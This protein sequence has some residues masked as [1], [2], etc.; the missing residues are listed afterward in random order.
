MDTVLI[1]G[2]GPAG[3]FCGLQA[4]GVGRR[5]VVLEK[6][7]ACGRKLL[8]TGTGQCN[9]THGG[10]VSE[11]L[12]HYGDHGTFLRPALMNFNNLDLI[13][14][15][16]DHGVRTITEP[17]GKVFPE[18]RKATEVLDALLNCCRERGVEVRCNE[19]VQEVRREQDGF[20]VRTEA[21]TYHAD[22]LVIA[23]GG[24]SY[25]ATGSTGDGYR[26]AGSLGHT[27][28]PV[29]PALAAVMVDGY[30]FADLSGISFAG[31]TISLFRDTKRV[32]QHTGDL[33]LTHHGLSGPGILDLSRHILPG[34]ELKVSFLPDMNRDGVAGDLNARIAAN[35]TRLVRTVLAEYQL[36]ERLVRRLV[37]M[38]GIPA[39]MTAAHLA[40]E[41]RK[42]LITLLTEC[43]FVV[44]NLEGFEA[45]MVTRGGVD[46]SEV[47]A[48]TMESRLVPHL[49]FA[50]EVLD[51]DGDT[52]GYNLQAA[53]STGALA[54]KKIAA[55]TR[56]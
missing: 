42:H 39:D 16:A 6:K 37:E 9:L 56:R 5:I 33:L 38:A 41:G 50:G 40:K 51:I 35:G 24:A 19:P 53:F 32:R 30:P 22:S 13:R 23:T 10:A 36:P 43:P 21:S 7:N 14:F 55:G 4:A 47:N 11:F 2:G 45:A 8:I 25:P 28:A 3:L 15:F 31:V 54:A 12:P 18:S 1:V 44:K 52:G 29:A 34:D 17:Q 26:I 20:L 27:I 46:L 49:F 48:K